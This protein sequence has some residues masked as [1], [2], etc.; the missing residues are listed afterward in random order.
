MKCDDCFNLL[1]E[2]I[3]GEAAERDAAQVS[4][5]LITC[6]TCANEFEALTAEREIYARYDRELQVSPSMWNAIAA[7]TAESRSSDS[8]SRLRFSGWLAGLFATPRYAF[9][10][11]AAVL[12]FAVVIGVVYLRT[13]KQPVQSE[14]SANVSN[15]PR[16]APDNRTAGITLPT[17]IDPTTTVDGTN[18]PR[19]KALSTS[20]LSVSKKSR[21]SDQTDVLFTDAA[22][23]D[24]EDK[25]TADHVERAQ[26]LLR[27]IRNL[28][29]SDD[30]DEVDVSYEK[31]TSRRLLNENVVL[32]RDAEMAGKFP[33]K[34]LLSDLEPFL[35]D[36]ANLPDKTTPTDLRA[37]KDRVQ[38]TEIVAAL[39]SY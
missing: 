25:E 23:S 30:D 27:S 1:E 31:A 28:Q 24:I 37:I 22:Y 5:H 15:S 2:Y 16:K 10:G 9:A 13:Q 19:V 7:R 26:N 11:A 32:R 21:W 8:G 29:V 3:D 6:A 35:I 33:T 34:T 38:K 17:G 39:R 4:A 20:T 18:T 14:A 36:I 12:I